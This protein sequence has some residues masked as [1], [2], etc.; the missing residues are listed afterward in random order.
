[1]KLFYVI[2]TKVSSFNKKYTTLINYTKNVP[3]TN[4]Q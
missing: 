1:M 4:L 2:V 3:F